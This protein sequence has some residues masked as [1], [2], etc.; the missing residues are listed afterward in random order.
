MFRRTRKAAHA[1]Q[2]TGSEVAP[3][4]VPKTGLETGLETEPEIAP[5][6]GPEAVQSSGQGEAVKP[7]NAQ[8]GLNRK[9]PSR[10]DFLKLT[11]VTI[12]AASL[13][14]CE[15]VDTAESVATPGEL[16][17][18]L[19]T[20]QQ[21]PEVPYT[22]TAPPPRNVLSFF[23]PQEARTLN[24][25]LAVLMP[26]SPEDPGAVEAGVLVYIDSTLTF[27]EGFVQ[28]TYRQPPFAQAYEGSTPP[29]AGE[30]QVVYVPKGVL[31][32]YGFQSLLTPREMY[33]T[34]LSALNG[35]TNAQHGKNFEDLSE[36]QQIG[37]VENLEDDAVSAFTQPSGK[38]F[39]QLVQTDTLDG[40]FGDPVYGG[41]RNFAG[42]RLVGFPGAQRAYTETDILTEGTTR[43][44]QSIV[45]LSAFNP[46]QPANGE[47]IL[48]VS[49]R[50]QQH[51][52]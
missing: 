2:D 52:N 40:M 6:T 7:V 22:P 32:R 36:A 37:L 17:P 50:D 30:F 1:A 34:G 9:G 45:N 26:G 49:G 3:K 31:P 4:I 43:E 42:W 28:P 39:F 21:Y 13:E 8:S 12:V 11:G 18:S 29:P 33:R 16:P 25:L 20:S 46:G 48:P 15:R 19:P 14:A 24:A 47:V 10:R 23:S 27:R 5:K 44:P 51:S 41:N 35:Y 38:E